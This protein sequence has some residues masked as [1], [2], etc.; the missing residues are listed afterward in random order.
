MVVPYIQMVTRVNKNMDQT[1][2]HVLHSFILPTLYQCVCSN[3]F[4]LNHKRIRK[5][6]RLTY[7]VPHF[8]IPRQKK[9][10]RNNTRQPQVKRKNRS[11]CVFSSISTTDYY[12]SIIVILHLRQCML[13]YSKFGLEERIKQLDRGSVSSNFLM[14]FICQFVFMVNK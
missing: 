9:H 1:E 12:T 7:Q 13:I 8:T 4:Q 2:S 11:V 14:V 6:M 10:K 3:V 5:R